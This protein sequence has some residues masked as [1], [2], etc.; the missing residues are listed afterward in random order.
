MPLLVLWLVSTSL[1]ISLSQ[2][3]L[4]FG[5]A[6]PQTSLGSFSQQAG[7][8]MVFGSPRVLSSHQQKVTCSWPQVTP[9]HGTA[10]LVPGGPA[11]E[12]PTGSTLAAEMVTLL[13]TELRSISKKVWS[14]PEF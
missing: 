13:L 2:E 9:N 4:Y 5:S 7:F 8:G 1:A 10:P 14:F 3:I 6:S 12:E 11:W